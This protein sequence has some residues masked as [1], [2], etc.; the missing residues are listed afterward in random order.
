MSGSRARDDDVERTFRCA[1][2]VLH[3]TNECHVH[4]DETQENNNNALSKI[5]YVSFWF[6]VE[7][8]QPHPV[9][10]VEYSYGTMWP[11]QVGGKVPSY[12]HKTVLR[13]THCRVIT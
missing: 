4:V 7:E 3:S 5:M 13:I 1:A 12:S 9:H 8:K 10:P 6:F 11:Y 2:N